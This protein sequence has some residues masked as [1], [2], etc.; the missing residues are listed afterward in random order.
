[1]LI[2]N[3]RLETLIE[4]T[5]LTQA[6]V[7]RLINRSTGCISMVLKNGRAS[8]QTVED[9]CKVLRITPDVLAPSP[10]AK[11]PEETTVNMAAIHRLHRRLD[12]METI[13]QDILSKVSALEEAWK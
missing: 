2:N 7:A 8:K 9:L 11:P 13:L 12:G 3:E 5:G 10:E 6:E 1:M 4:E